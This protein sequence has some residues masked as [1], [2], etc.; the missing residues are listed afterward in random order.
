MHG[1]RLCQVLAWCLKFITQ[2]TLVAIPYKCHASDEANSWCVTCLLKYPDP[3]FVDY[4]H[5]ILK[6]H[7]GFFGESTLPHELLLSGVYRTES[8]E[9]RIIRL[10]CNTILF[11]GDPPPR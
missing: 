11:C 6:A 9:E 7:L 1:S 3:L 4:G 10:R 8:R 2:S 5:V